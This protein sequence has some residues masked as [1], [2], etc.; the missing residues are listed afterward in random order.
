[1]QSKYLTRR[2]AASYLTEVRGLP[3]SWRTLQKLACIGGGPLYQVYGIYSLYTPDNLD[4][5]AEAKLSAPRHST[6][7]AC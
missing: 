7:D 6:S 3:T 5:W 4:T 2:E 1:M